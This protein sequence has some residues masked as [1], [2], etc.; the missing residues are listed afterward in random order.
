MW[1][2]AVTHSKWAKLRPKEKKKRA[3]MWKLKIQ[4]WKR[5]RFY[6][7]LFYLFLPVNFCCNCW[8]EKKISAVKPFGRRN[9]QWVFLKKWAKPGLFFVYF[10]S[11]SNKQYNFYNKSM[12]KMSCPSSIRR[13]DSNPWPLE[14][15]SPPIT[16]RPGLPP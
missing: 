13:L 2:K 3:K 16:T 8:K 15:E 12:W 10:Q 5:S 14:C 7:N 9:K 1:E 6:F 11:F 4:S